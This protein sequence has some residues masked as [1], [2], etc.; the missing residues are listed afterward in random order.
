MSLF[1]DAVAVQQGLG[2]PLPLAEKYR[3]RKL[4]DFLG[5]EKPRKVLSAFSLRPMASAWVFVGSPGTGKT[6][7][8]QALCEAIKGEFH[9]IPSQKC[10]ARSIDEVVRMCWY[11]PATPGGFHV[12][13]VD[14]A[15]CMTEGARLALLSKLDSTAKPPQTIW[16]FTC[17]CIEG[18]QSP[19]EAK[20]RFLSRC[21]VLEFSN[22]GLREPLVTFLAKVW[23]LETNSNPNVPNFERIAKDST[24]NCRDALMRLE[25][26]ILGV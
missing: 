14:E 22:Y 11:C 13:L 6:T 16:I 18:L 3:P 10:D 24:N 9:H 12:V 8:A 7:M 15:D 17:N 23:D 25:V 2:F 21:H 19:G 26:E 4:S 5:L 1:Q 20:N